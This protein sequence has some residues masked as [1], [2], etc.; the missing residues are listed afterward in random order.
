MRTVGHSAWNLLSVAAI[1]FWL[2]IRSGSCT[3][4][5]L[6]L[7]LD[8]GDD[9]LTRIAGVTVVGQG[10]VASVADS[11]SGGVTAAYFSAAGAE[12]S[13]VRFDGITAS[14]QWPYSPVADVAADASGTTVFA[15][16]E[17]GATAELHLMND[18]SV[19]E[20][21]A[22]LVTSFSHAT[23][24]KLRPDGMLLSATVAVGDDAGEV[25]G[26]LTSVPSSSSSPTRSSS[27][28]ASRS[29]SPSVTPSQSRSSTRS[30]SA[31]AS[32]SPT[33]T[34]SSTSSES[35]TGAYRV[36]LFDSL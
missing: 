34:P 25:V 1:A 32:S 20:S 26:C 7:L 10:V 3:G 30:A 17:T 4:P 5:T 18:G 6:S 36:L 31:T 22:Q 21:Q 13:S 9:S 29:R 15:L 14:S 11:S 33:A 19:R 16:T 35:T 12:Q 24:V 23:A 2:Q 28:S 27:V 8:L